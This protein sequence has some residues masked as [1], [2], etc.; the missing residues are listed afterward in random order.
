MEQGITPGNDLP[1]FDLDFGRVGIQICFD[2][3]FAENWQTLAEQGARLVLW[4][5]AYEG[6]FPL[7]VFAYQHHYW[8]VSS[9]RTGRSRIID[10]CGEILNE[11]SDTSPVIVRDINL[12]YVVAH[13]D[14]N[15]GIQDRIRAKYGERVEVRQWDPGSAHFVVEPRDPDLTCA[16]LQDEFG[17]ESTRQY[18]DRHRC[19][20]Q[21]MGQNKPAPSQKA[22]H[23]NRPQYGK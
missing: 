8:V 19:A 21:Q 2:I 9:T 20:Y 4:P 16:Q 13:W 6:G 14:W 11:T 18:H 1:V 22:R 5:S 10:P 3:G 17:F 12:D 7:R 23:G 15:M